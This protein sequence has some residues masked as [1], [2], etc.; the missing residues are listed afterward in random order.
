MWA[1]GWIY[2]TRGDC[3]AGVEAC[4]RSLERSVDPIN[5]ACAWAFIGYAYLGQDDA[6]QAIVALERS[7]EGCI[8]V[9]YRGLQGWFMAWL[10]DAYLLNHQIEPARHTALQGL[11][12]ARDVKNGYGIGWATR[13]LGR[14]TQARGA[15]AEAAGHLQ[16]A[17]ATF[18]SIQSRLEV[19]RTHLDLAA[20]AHA[21]D[22]PETTA[23]HC[24]AAHAVFT[25]L[26]LPLYVER[27]AQRASEY[28]VVLA[29]LAQ[30]QGQ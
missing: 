17:L 2:A 27:A 6:G 14:I 25:A 19:G 21:Q 23:A 18:T 29:A 3:Q 9:Q 8:Q 30:V 22:H 15:F 1:I 10:S 11:D 13:A 7:I 5:T 28:G 20:L 16:Q 26:H 4:Q 12:I 24:H